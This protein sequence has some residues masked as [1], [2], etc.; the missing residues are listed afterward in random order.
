MK[1]S[2]ASFDKI[3][4]ITRRVVA[5]ILSRDEE[6]LDIATTHAQQSMIGKQIVELPEEKYNELY[7]ERIDNFL[8]LRHNKE[9]TASRREMPNR[10]TPDISDVSFKTTKQDNPNP[11]EET[12]G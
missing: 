9:L 3:D 5:A 2:K 4:P 6:R 7:Q 1:K 12:N 8:I 10:L 11:Q